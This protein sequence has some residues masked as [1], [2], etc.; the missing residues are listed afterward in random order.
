[1]T[2]PT[3]E[4]NAVSRQSIDALIE[5]KQYNAAQTDLGRLWRQ[6]PTPATA[7]FIVSRF[8]K[9]RDHL[10]L[11]QSR[12]AI[13]RSFTVEPVVPLL[14]A[15]GFLGGLDLTV[16]VG[17]FNTYAQEILDPSS[18]LY[19]F[20]PDIAILAVQTA[21]IAPALWESFADL[22]AQAAE[23]QVEQTVNTFRQLVSR[24]RDKSKAQLLIHTLQL[25]PDAAAGV[26]DA[27]SQA[28]QT[29][30]IDKINHALAQIARDHNNV[31]LLDLNALIA[32]RG[33]D[34]F[35]D[36]RKHLTVG[37]PIAANELIHLARTWLRYLHPMTGKVCKVLAIDLDNTLWGGVIGEDGMEGIK[38]GAGYPGAA[39]R[40][41]QRVMLDLY[42][43][44]ILLAVCSKNNPP[45]A[46][47]A[48][49][50][51]P[52]MLLR[53][54]QFAALRINWQDK[55]TNLREL[56]KDLNLGIDSI[57]FIDD[58]PVEREWV[59]G[60]VPEV[61]IIDL[62]E[63]PMGFADALRQ[64]PVFERLKLSEEDRSRGQYYAQ[65]RMRDE[66][67]QTTGSL[68]DFY[69]SLA[70]VVDI[71]PVT[72]SNLARAAQLTQKTNQFNMT[73]RR[74]T[75]EQVA[76]MTP[77]VW[78]TYTIRVKDRFG[79]NGIV[80]LAL[81]KLE[82]DICRIDTFLLSCRVI[83][84]TVETAFLA[85]I[86]HDAIHAGASKLVGEFLPT[87]KNAP[88]K[89]FYRQHGFTLVSEKAGNQ[90]W[91]LSLKPNPLAVPQWIELHVH[92][93]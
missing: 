14:R 65:D 18:R 24:F 11:V 17:D 2:A 5:S 74:Y 34:H 53:P 59:R 78:R 80:G 19:E 38:L 44:G 31:Y 66:L 81:V 23:A 45:E 82:S 91:E 61:T 37:M 63:D 77:P 84:R 58:N 46:T 21:D 49:E 40:N 20:A 89:D 30:A 71:E 88:A 35:Y 54:D 55:G 42:R 16:Q 47:E 3:T 9:M 51:H 92:P 26:L 83:G 48:I 12:V 72:K 50:K 70:M 25:P 33:W 36:P 79:D 52:G 4:S 13:L 27:Q 73:T 68:E 10:P 8:E 62:P 87:K 15:M 22:D 93:G 7:S 32:R 56:A 29:A 85:T 86:A 28:G 57:A 6:T 67:Q 69:K 39:Y 90:V 75:E 43:R 64:A 41:L 1:V 60:Q 76:A